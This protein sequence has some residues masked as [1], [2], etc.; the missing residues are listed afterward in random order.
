[1]LLVCATFWISPRGDVRMSLE[2]WRRLHLASSGLLCAI[3]TIHIGVTPLVYSSGRLTRC[4]FL[5]PASACCCSESL[6]SRRGGRPCRRPTAT[7]VRRTNGVFR[8]TARRTPRSTGAPGGGDGSLPLRP[9]GGRPT[10][11]TRPRVANTYSSAS[12]AET[13]FP[14]LTF[15]SLCCSTRNSITSAR[16][17]TVPR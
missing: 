14:S 8:R 6:T 9:G 13:V 3:A 15:V 11:I 17:R 12:I 5:A 4:G 7:V 2:G 1:M 16:W 10:D